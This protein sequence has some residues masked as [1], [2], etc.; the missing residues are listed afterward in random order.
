M[1]FSEE[2]KLA[3]NDY[4]YEISPI[5]GYKF[6]KGSNIFTSF[7]KKYYELK[8]RYK[9]KGEFSISVIAKML[10]NSL[11][12]KLGMKSSKNIVRYVNKEESN[13]IHLYHNVYDNFPFSEDLEYIKY[14]AVINDHFYDLHGLEEYGQLS[15]KLDINNKEFQTSLPIAIAISSYARMYMHSVIQH[16][17]SLGGEVYYIDTDSIVTDVELPAELVGEDIGQFKLEF[18]AKEAYFIAPKLYYLQNNDN[19]IIKAKTLGGDCLKKKDFEDMS[20]GRMIKKD[21]KT[22][23]SNIKKS[24]ISLV[25]ITMHLNPILRKRQSHFQSGQM[26]FTSPVLVK[27]GIVIDNREF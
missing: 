25:D 3:V 16:V 24:K 15:H 7:V 8:K 19:I 5:F 11:F 6:E 1:Y 18:L 23:L 13:S 4:G 27:E 14:S 26:T 9:E 17:L 12:G 21:R 22:F 20:Y 10:M 2:L